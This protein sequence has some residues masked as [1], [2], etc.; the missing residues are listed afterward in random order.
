MTHTVTPVLTRYP[1]QPCLGK[2]DE[3]TKTT[4]RLPITGN[5]NGNLNLAPSKSN[6]K[7]TMYGHS[8]YH[9]YIHIAQGLVWHCIGGA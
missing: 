1:T 3:N 6:R 9:L 2:E 8:T 5:K 7:Q 4:R